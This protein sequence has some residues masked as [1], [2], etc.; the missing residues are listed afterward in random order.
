VA[1]RGRPFDRYA[2]APAGGTPVR[3]HLVAPT[4][5]LQEIDTAALV[6][7]VCRALDSTT[8]VVEGWHAAPL[9]GGIAT[10]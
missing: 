7:P 6:L 2:D 10:P 4:G 3:R 1:L 8:A 5:R 9:I